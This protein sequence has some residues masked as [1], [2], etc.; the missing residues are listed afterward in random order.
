VQGARDASGFSLTVRTKGDV[1]PIRR[2]L[3][4]TLV[5]VDAGIVFSFREY[6]DQ[7]GASVAQERL[8]AMLS[9]FFG[10]LALLLAGLGL[11]GVT[12]YTVSRRRGEIA[13]RMALG[14]HPAGVM[15]LVLGRVGV[16]LT[17]GVATGL[18]L[19]LWLVTF[20]GARLFDLDRRDPLTFAG[21]TL[22]LVLV[23]LFAGWL[24]ARRA[25]PMSP[26]EAL[27]N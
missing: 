14:A 24:P 7:I 17:L 15:W 23:G 20:V 5:R 8:V 4:D 22:V 3:A 6:A 19:S 11:Y 25:A 13:V 9:G 21:A 12:S 10:V 1:E 2:A 16:L 27:R 18:G 26:T